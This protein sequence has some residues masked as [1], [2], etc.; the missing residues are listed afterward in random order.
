MIV[1][2]FYDLL[3]FDELLAYFKQISEAA[4]I[5]IMF[6]NL[7]GVTGIELSAEEF[8]RLG[9]ETNV[10]SFKNTGGDI[11]KLADVLF[12]HSEDITPLNGGDLFTFD[13]FALGAT[14]GVWGGA[15]FMPG[16][17]SELYKA[18]AIDKDLDRA[19]ELW[20]QIYPVCL[21]LE[22]HNYAAA[23]KTR[24]S[25]VGIDAGPTRSPIAP[26]EQQYRDELAGLLKTAGIE[27]K[28]R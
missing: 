18:L 23:I 26:L 7:P 17:A 11:T 15:S 16:P 1:P 3:N 8:G 14:A 19:R 22:S 20:R 9:R 28:G 24:V 6:Y 4:D 25:L 21:F 13:G 2:P 27:V 10:T 12:H 5:P